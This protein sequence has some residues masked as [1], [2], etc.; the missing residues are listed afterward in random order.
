MNTLKAITYTLIIILGLLVA[1]ASFWILL[2]LAVAVILF[3]TIRAWN[4]D[5][6][7]S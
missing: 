4:D 5:T 1:Y 6:L 7:I 3:L 2:V